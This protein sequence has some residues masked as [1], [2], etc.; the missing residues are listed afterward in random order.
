MLLAGRCDGDTLGGMER[1]ACLDIRCYTAREA[2]PLSS[3]HITDAHLPAQLQLHDAVTIECPLLFILSIIWR[4]FV[5]D[6]RNS[7][8]PVIYC[9]TGNSARKTVL[10]SLCALNIKRNPHGLRECVTGFLFP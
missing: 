5:R 4:S 1:E 9:I 8:Y 10:R 2:V 6:H 7:A 3:H